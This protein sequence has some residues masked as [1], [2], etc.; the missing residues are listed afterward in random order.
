MNNIH[1]IEL[2]LLRVLL[3]L[4]ETQSVSL[5]ASKL[6]LTQSAV[7]HS[8][9]LLRNHFDDALFVRSGHTMAPTSLAEALCPA[10][11]EALDYLGQAL[12]IQGS[13]SPDISERTFTLA[14]TDYVE[15]I[16]FP[17]I[18]RLLS[19]QAPGVKLVARPM[20]DHQLAAMGRET[21]IAIGHFPSLPENFHRVK[22]WHESFTTI[23][24]ADHPRV[25][26]DRISLEQFLRE[27]HILISPDGS[28][29]GMVDK[30]LL[31]MGQKRIVQH[32]S[33]GF[34]SPGRWVASTEFIATIPSSIANLLRAELP[35]RCLPPPL[36]L[37]GYDVSLVW[38]DVNH[39]DAG[40]Q[41]LRQL[42]KSHLP[43]MTGH[44]RQTEKVK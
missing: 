38:N 5:T 7:S 8:L 44:L 4:K 13:F 15:A 40:H 20:N 41:W 18:L 30:E 36:S 9:K 34:L 14:V 2:R 25:T 19:S 28:G 35:V 10:I 43:E 6:Q 42:I 33:R 16:C 22:L 39:H 12:R 24:S 32:T 1:N 3:S 21:E 37:Q 26:S 29:F 27:K 23:V 11:R 31:A 17:P